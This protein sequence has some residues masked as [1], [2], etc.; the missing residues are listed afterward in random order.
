MRM[1]MRS[2]TVMPPITAPAIRPGDGVEEGLDEV[3]AVVG[4]EVD[5]E[6]FV[7]VVV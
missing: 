3:A 2:R 1:P 6:V 5:C 7:V 4:E